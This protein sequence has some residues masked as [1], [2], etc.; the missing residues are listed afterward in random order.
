VNEPLCRAL[1]RARLTE[2]DLAAE[3][4][5]DPKT[6]RRWLEGRVPYPRHR[7]ALAALL[8]ADE[9]DLW[10][11]LGAQGSLPSEVLAIY[12]RL[13]RVPREVWL[14]LFGSARNEIG[15]LASG[16]LSHTDPE[17]MALVA[18]RVGRGARVRICLA[19]PNASKGGEPGAEQRGRTAAGQA[20][21]A[22]TPSAALAGA[23]QVLIRVHQG[24]LYQSIYRADS[25]LL[26]AQH[27]YGIPP[28]R[29]PVLHLQ[30][31]EHG[32]MATAYLE[33]FEQVWAKARRAP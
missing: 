25:Q 17:V 8:G 15:V 11:Q 6:V 18:A 33:S 32:D 29:T 28:A 16:G 7:W 27:A 21:S 3:L 23:G 5:V 20:R 1:L 13:D 4:Q 31:V 30:R 24:V 22:L 19:V 12:P 2:D 26:V 10:P 14:D 9:A